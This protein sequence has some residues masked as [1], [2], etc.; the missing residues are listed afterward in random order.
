MAS[1]VEEWCQA[2]RF[3]YLAAKTSERKRLEGE[4]LN[5]WDARGLHPFSVEVGR[6]LAMQN[7]IPE[8]RDLEFSAQVIRD[9]AREDARAEVYHDV[10]GLA[11]TI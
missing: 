2:V 6:A 4:P 9:G 7:V 10:I 8:L 3:A 11:V 5:T 1:E